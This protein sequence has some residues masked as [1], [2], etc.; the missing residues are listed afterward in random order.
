[1]A[2]LCCGNT[3]NIDAIKTESLLVLIRVEAINVP[4]PL[5][6][7]FPYWDLLDLE[8]SL[9]VNSSGLFTHLVPLI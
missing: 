7:R 5:L 9:V 1:M 4:R 6:P 8:L 2:F 3:T